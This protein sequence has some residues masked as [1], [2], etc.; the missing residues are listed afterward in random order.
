MSVE[1]LQSLERSVYGSSRQARQ[2]EKFAMV[3]IVTFD[4]VE[5]SSPNYEYDRP[6]N[7]CVSHLGVYFRQKSA[8]YEI[9]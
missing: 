1:T 8:Q 7:L 9:F 4:F 3:E 6:D 2:I 5:L